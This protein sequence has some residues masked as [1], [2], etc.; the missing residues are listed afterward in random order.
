MYYLIAENAKLKYCFL[1]LIGRPYNWFYLSLPQ[2][3]SFIS[4]TW[5]YET[6]YFICLRYCVYY[7]FSFLFSVSFCNLSYKTIFQWRCWLCWYM[8][9]NANGIAQ[10]NCIAHA[11]RDL[12][13]IVSIYFAEVRGDGEPNRGSHSWKWNLSKM[14]SSQ[15]CWRN[16]CWRMLPV[17][18]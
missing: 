9:G 6:G 10:I 3:F 14:I 8:D 1:N 16:C 18:L 5:E 13:N 12:M 17:W 2:I 4:K 11:G 15:F 7:S